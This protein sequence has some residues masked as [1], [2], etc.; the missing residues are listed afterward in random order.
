MNLCKTVLR[1]KKE[2]SAL[3]FLGLKLVCFGTF[4]AKQ[5][6]TLLKMGLFRT[7]THNFM[8]FLVKIQ[9]VE[10]KHPFYR[11]GVSFLAAPTF[12][13][14]QEGNSLFVEIVFSTSRNCVLFGGHFEF[15]AKTQNCWYL[16]NGAR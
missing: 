2:K 15:S 8:L 3:C 14:P 5:Q 11:K 7:K 12:P 1:F 6:K 13:T 9:R 10:T 4:A 16:L